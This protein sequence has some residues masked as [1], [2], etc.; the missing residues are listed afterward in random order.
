MIPASVGGR[1]LRAEA[2]LRRDADTGRAR[3]G[4]DG[5]AGVAV[6]ALLQAVSL[7]LS[8]CPSC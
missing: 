6:D 8:A 3:F 5:N 1:A 4:L 7:A 2:G